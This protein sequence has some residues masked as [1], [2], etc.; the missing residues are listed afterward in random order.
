MKKLFFVL[1]IVAMSAAVFAQ[2][3]TVVEVG[4]KVVVDW[5]GK[6]AGFPIPEWVMKV[7][8]EDDYGVENALGIDRTKSQMFV[9]QNRFSQEEYISISKDYMKAALIQKLYDSVVAFAVYITNREQEANKKLVEQRINEKIINAFNSRGVYHFTYPA[10]NTSLAHYFWNDI[11]KEKLDSNYKYAV[12]K[13]AIKINSEKKVFN[14]AE[15]AKK[16]SEDLTDFP[17]D[18]T[19]IDIIAFKESCFDDL[20]L[21]KKETFWTKTVTLKPDAKLTHGKEP[22]AKD[23]VGC[24]Y[25]VYEVHTMP[26]AKFIELLK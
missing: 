4:R 25:T 13:S 7:A 19:Y 15:D 18:K 14:N 20:S 12:T 2:S 9:T 3:K 23:V 21:F 16:Y 10:T 8:E 6:S 26:M 11:A 17:R 22:K 24:D 5:E 1:A